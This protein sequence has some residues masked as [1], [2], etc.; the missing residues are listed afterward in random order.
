MLW[1]VLWWVVYLH[2]VYAL[3][4]SETDWC[5]CVLFCLLYAWVFLF[6]LVLTLITC[7]FVVIVDTLA[8]E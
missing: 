1:I 2:Y 6:I 3:L 8:S 7:Y 4:F 5:A